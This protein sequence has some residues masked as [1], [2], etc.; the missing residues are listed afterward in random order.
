MFTYLHTSVIG[1]TLAQ[2]SFVLE[3]LVEEKGADCT[4]I[5]A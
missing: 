2:E 4:I 5:P 1:N 3:E